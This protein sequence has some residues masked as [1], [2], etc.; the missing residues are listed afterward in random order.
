[1]ASISPVT[2][3]IIRNALQSAAEEMNASLFRS[4]FSPVIYEM[5][6][7]SVG[8]FDEQ[9]RILGQSAGLPIFLGNLEVCIQTAIE[10]YGLDWFRPG[11]VICM[12]D[13]YMTGTH[14]NDITV[15]SPVF[16][17]GELVGFTANRAHW[18]DVGAKDPGM[19]TDT[20]EIYQEGIRIGPTKI[21][22]AGV[23]R[24]DVIDLITR[25]SRFPVAARGDLN[26]QISACRTGERRFLAIIRRW[27]LDTVRAA[28]AE[29]F[30]QSERLDREAIAA[31]PDGTYF[32]EGCLDND[33]VSDEPVWVRVT[34]TVQGSDITIDLTGSSPQ[35]PGATNCGLAQTI[36]AC[37]VA[38]KALINPD[39]PVTGGTFRP[40]RVT[41]P[42]GSIFAAEEPAATTW[43]FSHLGLL[44]DLVQKALAPAIP[45]RV[46]A[47]HYGDSMVVTFVG[48]DPE[49]NAPFFNLEATVGG[50]G[51]FE[52]GDG[53][54]ALI[55]SVNGDFRNLPVEVLETKYPILVRR[56]SLRPDSG[57]PGR[58]RGGTGAVRE[59]ELQADGALYLWW[60]RSRCPAWG[61]MGGGDGSPPQV[62]VWNPRADGSWEEV[63]VLKANGLPLRRGAVVTCMTGG[64]GGYGDPFQR[65]PARVR[66]DVLDGYVSREA[67]ARQY[68]VAIRPDG[69]IDEAETARLRAARG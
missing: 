29:I 37:R 3:E 28:C 32:A 48:H 67:A 20:R 24:E 15:F 51:A 6:D 52:G 50:W 47:A 26:A 34:V 49:R 60:E 12:N 38:Y 64:G 25:N 40:L 54:D 23:P 58:F 27:G 46:A 41:V 65:E 10:M 33:G 55:N 21:V 59:Y 63:R 8:L 42:P 17:E 7:C 30:A 22:D 13:S 53:Q 1:M 66:E 35:R 5:K 16:H 56:Y 4:A 2:V 69:Q 57:G 68:G 61:L 18:L 36:S 11:D 14:L 39:A 19:S 44:I 43:Y 62:I 45:D 9:A 31:I